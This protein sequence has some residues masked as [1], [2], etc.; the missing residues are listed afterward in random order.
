MT[1]GETRS[2]LRKLFRKGLLLRMGLAVILYLFTDEFLF[3]PDQNTYRLLGESLARYW[4]GETVVFPPRLL[5]GGPTGYVYIVAA[6]FWM[7][8][9]ALAAQLLNCVVGALTILIVFDLARR[10]TGNTTVALRSAMFVAYFP[11][12]VLWSAL[13]IRDAWIIMLIALIC[14]QALVL[15]EKVTFTSFVILAGAIWM[16]IQFRD[17]VLLAVTVPMVLSFLVRGR[18]HLGRNVLLGMVGTILVIYA[19]QA[20]GTGRKVRLLDLEELQSIRHWN[21]YGA[22]SQFEQA[23]ISTPEKALVFLPKG[24]AFFLLAPF[25]WM[26]GSIR[27]ILAVPEM[28]FFYSLLPSI[29]RGVRYLLRYHLGNALMVILVTSGLTIGY[30]LGEGNAGTAYRHRAQLLSFYLIF[31]AVGIE[32][33]RASRVDAPAAALARPRPI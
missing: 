19:D 28:L 10:M 26:L 12:L 18:S 13:N 21:A 6:F 20:A 17:Y 25:P 29:V 1:D 32:A 3:A 22:A 2:E 24:L 7:G 23:D 15:Q 16:L 27:Q 9:G 33:R 8:A 14:R 4:T 31:A 11:S 30:A 5:A